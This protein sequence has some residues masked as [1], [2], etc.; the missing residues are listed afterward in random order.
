[1]VAS[2]HFFS[3]YVLQNMYFI[4]SIYVVSIFIYSI[5][6]FVHLFF[7][8]TFNY[9]M[10]TKIIVNVM[11]LF[12]LVLLL[13]ISLIEQAKHNYQ[14]R[15][16]A[17]YFSGH[18]KHEEDCYS[19]KDYHDLLKERNSYSRIVAFLLIVRLLF[20]KIQLPFFTIQGPMAS[21]TS[22][23]LQFHIPQV[24]HSIQHLSVQQGSSV[25]YEPRDLP[26]HIHINSD[27]YHFRTISYHC[28][29]SSHCL[30]QFLI[31][32]INS[33]RSLSHL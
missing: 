14:I 6:L 4:F 10:I 17:N 21:D 15:Y 7:L 3:T 12:F 1:M 16:Q 2:I 9:N 24:F 20:L 29:N 19:N 31:L 28:L 33:Q 5:N 18:G 22:L 23:L 13:A 26:S 25:Q 27:F 32:I 8:M 30:L 11:Q